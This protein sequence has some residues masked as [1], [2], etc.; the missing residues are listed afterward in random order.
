MKKCSKSNSAAVMQVLQQFS[1]C[2]NEGNLVIEQLDD[3][4]QA[5]IF[6][7][8][9]RDGQP[10]QQEHSKLIIKLYKSAG[11]QSVAVARH[12]FESLSRLH[13][14]LDSSTANG[15]RIASPIPLFQCQWP[16]ALVMTLVPGMPLKDCLCTGDAHTA[17]VLD[18]IADAM[19]AAMDGFWSH[20]G[21]YGELNFDNILCDVPGRTIS[22]V[23]TGGRDELILCD[24]VSRNWYPASHDLGYLLY[25]IET[26]LRTFIRNPGARL[27]QL[28]LVEQILR[29]YVK[30]T[31][32]G[33]S[34]QD[35]LDEIGACARLHLTRIRGAWSPGGAWRLFVR[36][37]ASRGIDQILARLKS[38]AVVPMAGVC[39]E[40]AA[41]GVR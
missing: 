11:P 37:N 34:A 23:D 26:S 8:G 32:L 12:Q 21:L 2:P 17:D 25:D 13:A 36:K 6:A 16:L 40:Y 18:S 1:G 24:V 28:Y 20:G 4:G 3:G 31:E 41:G 29:S 10:I 39:G 22:F 38:D 14:G 9:R 5:Y 7:I 30:K 35:L 27:R 19:I 15:W 33:Y